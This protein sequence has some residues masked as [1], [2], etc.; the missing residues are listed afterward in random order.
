MILDAL[1]RDDAP[2]E[3]DVDQPVGED[4]LERGAARRP[5]Q[6]LG[7]DGDGHHARPPEA[8]LLELVAVELRIAEREVDPPGERAE[9]LPPERRQPE[10][11]W[12]VRRKERRR[13]DVVILEHA[14]PGQAGERLGHRRRQGEVEDRDVA[15]P[16]RVVAE[17]TDV[18]AQVVVDRQR[19]EVGLVPGGAQ[20]VA[21][22][23][24]AVADGVA[25]VR[26]RHPLVDDHQRASARSGS[27]R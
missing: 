25:A 10:Q 26:R 6:A 8:Q 9:L 4:L 12:V 20:Q 7:V 22:P 23:A 5:G 24:R 2:D 17:R 21:D 19:E 1:V 16:R 3:Q 18:L 11:L 13:R 27:A 15:A 14:A